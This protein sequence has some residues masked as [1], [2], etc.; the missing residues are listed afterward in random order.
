MQI[1]M[2]DGEGPSAEINETSV[3]EVNAGVDG[4]VVAPV[5][6]QPGGVADE[7]ETVA[8]IVDEMEREDSDNER[9]EEGDS[10]DEET[11]INPAE[12]AS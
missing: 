12:W 6:I 7:E 3:E 5:G 11:D 4:G 2:D 8:A 9:V 1:N 10:S